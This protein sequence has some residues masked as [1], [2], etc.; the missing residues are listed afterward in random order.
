VEKEYSAGGDDEPNWT[1]HGF[2]DDVLFLYFLDY[3]ITNCDPAD[4]SGL[5]KYTPA[6]PAEINSALIGHSDGT[7]HGHSGGSIDMYDPKWTTKYPSYPSFKTA[8]FQ[9]I[10]DIALYPRIKKDNDTFTG[11]PTN[12]DNNEAFSTNRLRGSGKPVARFN[13]QAAFMTVAS[14]S[15][16]VSHEKLGTDSTTLND[17]WGWLTCRDFGGFRVDPKGAWG[18]GNGDCNKFGVDLKFTQDGVDS[19]KKLVAIETAEIKNTLYVNNGQDPW[20]M[21]SRMPLQCDLG[22]TDPAAQKAWVCQITSEIMDI[23]DEP[24]MQS[25]CVNSQEPVVSE[26]SYVRCADHG[27]NGYQNFYVYQGGHCYA[28]IENEPG[29]LKEAISKKVGEWLA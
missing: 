7:A 11:C 9:Q 2:S 8:N 21:L 14:G 4:A 28:L 6:V 12:H 17:L 24:S 27:S 1:F 22:A 26:G 19:F 25:Q 20:S 23:S 3:T 16:S 18:E 5:P 29:P 13:D 10:C 15:T